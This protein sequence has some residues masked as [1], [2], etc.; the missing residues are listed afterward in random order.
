[1]SVEYPGYPENPSTVVEQAFKKIAQTQD[2]M[3][4]PFYHKGIQTKTFSF[5][6]FEEQW[7][8]VLLTPWLLS[9]VIFPGA[10]QV[11]PQRE[12]GDKLGLSFPRG[13]VTF[14]VSEIEGLGQYLSC[15]LMSP[16]DR[17]VH[18]IVYEQLAEDSLKELLGQKDPD[19]NAPLDPKRR[20]IMLRSQQ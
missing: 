15:S 10:N 12:I 5:Q 9:V 13:D 14:V 11:W 1:M 8:G 18:Q 2:M 16:L 6:E 17:L 7:I 4:L 20:F 19:T 3:E